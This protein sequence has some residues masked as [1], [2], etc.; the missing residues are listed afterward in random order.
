MNRQQRLAQIAEADYKWRTSLKEDSDEKVAES[1][2][3]QEAA[4]HALV[5]ENE[6]K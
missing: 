4:W 6:H 5:A 1:T 2:P 3:E